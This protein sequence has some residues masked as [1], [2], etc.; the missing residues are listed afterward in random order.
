MLIPEVKNIYTI[1]REKHQRL[2]KDFYRT[3][4][5]MNANVE[6]IEPNTVIVADFNLKTFP[7]VITPD[8]QVLDVSG[9][10]EFINTNKKPF[11]EVFNEEILTD[12]E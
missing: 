5:E 3:C 10:I 7:C 2:V 8:D 4:K 1:V 6:I 12:K 11:I 9:M